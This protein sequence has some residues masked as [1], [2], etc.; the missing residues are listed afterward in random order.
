MEKGQM[1]CKS[2]KKQLHGK[3][4]FLKCY[5]SWTISHLN[6]IG[7]FV[8]GMHTHMLIKEDTDGGTR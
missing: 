3:F 4:M 2:C 5:V 6:H 1:C 8:Q 7:N